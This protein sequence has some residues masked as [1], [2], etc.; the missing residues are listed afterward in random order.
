MKMSWGYEGMNTGSW[1]NK[2]PKK[3]IKE[4]SRNKII[5]EKTK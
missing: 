4:N 5:E 1:G 2:K 3:E